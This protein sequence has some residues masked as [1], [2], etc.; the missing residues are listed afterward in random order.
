MRPLT[1]TLLAAA[2]EMEG[3]VSPMV[4]EAL[5]RWYG[6]GS[7][8][9]RRDSA[10]GAVSCPDWDGG[11][12]CDACRQE[13]CSPWGTTLLREVCC[14]LWPWAADAI[15]KRSPPPGGDEEIPW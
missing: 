9:A 5:S 1:E 2:C 15:R 13:R 6:P 14:V 8:W 7:E 12:W 11:T 3:D 4:R 10:L